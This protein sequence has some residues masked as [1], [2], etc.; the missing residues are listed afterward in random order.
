LLFS[1]LNFGYG[2]AV[3]MALFLMVMAVSLLYVKHAVE[4]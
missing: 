2:S 4:Q 3:S 1:H